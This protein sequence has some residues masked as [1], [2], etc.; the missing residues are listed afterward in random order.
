MN[1][2]QFRIKNIFLLVWCYFKFV[3]YGRANK[4]ITD[5]RKILVVQISKLGDMVCTTPVFRAIKLKFP[6][7]QVYVLGSAINKN[8]LLNH[9]DVNGYI[10]L[11][12]N[13]FK[14]IKEIKKEKFDF[15][16]LAMPDLASL[17][18]AY[19][20]GIPLI[21]A[22]KIAT[23]YS[24]YNTKPFRL[25]AQL[26][27]TKN[28]EIKNYMP[29][30]YLKLLEPIGIYT[31]E[32]Q[33]HLIYSLPA[34]KMI[35]E[36]FTQYDI[37]YSSDFI[38]GLSPA[39][40]NKIKL[41]SPAKFAGLIDYIHSRYQVKIIIIGT[42]ADTMLVNKVI[43]Y[44][45]PASQ[46]INTAGRFDLEEVKALIAKMS[47]FIS[48][49]TGPIFIA[50][51][52]EVPTIDIVGPVDENVQPPNGEFHKIVKVERDRAEI[53]ILNASDYNYQEAKRQIDEITVE[54][55]IEKFEEL[56]S[57]INAAG[58]KTK[59]KFRALAK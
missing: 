49:D 50:E 58:F 57:A 22:P 21:C 18:A 45:N 17:A 7:S 8:L 28:Y 39:A 38:I 27:V 44:L 16:C 42:L 23:G 36:F 3:V 51:A 33:K 46:A 34:G 37:N 59:I 26:V 55:V 1:K 25:A 48:V 11:S 20:A 19:L 24:P 40:G 30:E 54:M 5:P 4:N 32:T 52:F 9:P 43:S 35:E 29:G 6:Q 13:T 14:L 12:D 56:I 41:W 2:W 47:L 31:K 15:A 10:V 53:Y